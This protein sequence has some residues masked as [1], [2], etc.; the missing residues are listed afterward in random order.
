MAAPFSAVAEDFRQA[1]GK[2]R[3]RADSDSMRPSV[4]FG[5]VLVHA[6][7]LVLSPFA[8]G[9]CRFEPSCSAY[10]L[11]AVQTHGLVRGSGSRFDESRAATR[12]RGRASIPCRRPPPGADGTAV[13]LHGKTRF[14]RDLSLVRRARAVPVVLR[15]EA[16]AATGDG[17]RRR[18][19]PACRRRRTA[20]AVA[21]P[22]A[23]PSAV[24]RRSKR[25]RRSIR[26]HATSWSR[27]TTCAP[28]SRP[29]ARRS[30][31]G[32]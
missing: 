15:A 30:R 1:L 31:A 17:D 24:P 11:D 12:S 21:G 4:R 14:L 18:W 10:A 28:S 6:Y 19:R 3:G 5:L 8:G 25:R 20:P 7:Q 2:L 22:A 32:A 27:P 23:A 16:G 13:I 9:A 26:P 29:P